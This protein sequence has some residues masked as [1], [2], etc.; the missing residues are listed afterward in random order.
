MFWIY[1]GLYER[2]SADRFGIEAPP[3]EFAY[4]EIPMAAEGMA[5]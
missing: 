2:P 1:S 4:Q 5:E 3:D